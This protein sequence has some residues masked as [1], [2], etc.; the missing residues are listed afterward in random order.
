MSR[1]RELKHTSFNG[2]VCV[3]V[4][5]K[6]DFAY[7]FSRSRNCCC[8]CGCVLSPNIFV[9]VFVL[10]ALTLLNIQYFCASNLF[11]YSNKP[12]QI[13]ARTRDDLPTH[14]RL[15]RFGAMRACVSEWH[16]VDWIGETFIKMTDKLRFGV[17]VFVGKLYDFYHLSA[18][19]R[20][21]VVA[22]ATACGKCL[23]T[24]HPSSQ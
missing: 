15:V 23:S 10:N 24:F 9:C 1:K 5:L 22:A 20:C 8:C 19:S 14:S 4:P 17:N 18:S 3:H 16:A 11:S 7:F 21:A 6:I 12:I 2:C 13:E